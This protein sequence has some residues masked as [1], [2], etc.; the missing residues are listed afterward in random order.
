L[1]SNKLGD[2]GAKCLASCFPKLK[3]LISMRISVNYNKIG[4]EGRECLI[5]S[6]RKLQKTKIRIDLFDLRSLNNN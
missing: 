1:I 5:I 4:K 2:E 6:L 3:E